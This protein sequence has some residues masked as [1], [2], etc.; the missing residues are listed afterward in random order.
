M[1][2]IKTIIILGSIPVAQ[3]FQSC[4]TELSDIV[5]TYQNKYC[6][7]L[8]LSEEFLYIYESGQHT[9]EG[10]WKLSSDQQSILLMNW[11]EFDDSTTGVKQVTIKN[12]TIWISEDDRKKNFIKSFE[13]H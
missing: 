6:E 12:N 11:L 9:S 13:C 10:K 2:F 3:V 8:T 1:N 4:S 7:K 5:G